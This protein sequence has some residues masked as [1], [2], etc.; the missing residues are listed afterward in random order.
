MNQLSQDNTTEQGKIVKI[1]TCNI[2]DGV[3]RA[4]AKDYLQEDKSASR[5]FY[6]EVRKYDLGVSELPLDQ[7]KK[8]AWC[9][10][11]NAQAT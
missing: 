9:I 10:C 1:S 5:E 6:N 7:Y 4:A 11:K 2:C 8:T 3:V